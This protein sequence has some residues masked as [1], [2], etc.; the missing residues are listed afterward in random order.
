M[1]KSVT[2]NFREIDDKSIYFEMPSIHQNDIS[3]KIAQDQD[4]KT[5]KKMQLKVLKILETSKEN[6]FIEDWHLYL[7]KS[8]I[9]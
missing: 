8:D 5:L 1:P 4:P 2:N 7:R 9:L 6:K 3:L